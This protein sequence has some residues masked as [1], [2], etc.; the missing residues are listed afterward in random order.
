[1]QSKQNRHKIITIIWH[2]PGFSVKYCR[3]A[4]QDRVSARKRW[5]HLKLRA[6][7]LFLYLDAFSAFDITG[8]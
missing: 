8:D 6:G 2:R 1:M 7:G 5:R 3:S 4:C